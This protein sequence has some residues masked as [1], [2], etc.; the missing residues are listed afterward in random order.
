MRLFEKPLESLTLVEARDR[1]HHL[2]RNMRVGDIEAL[3][4]NPQDLAGDT[5]FIRVRKSVLRRL[6][7]LVAKRNVT[8]GRSPGPMYIKC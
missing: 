8:S 7:E 5:E 3:E 2:I 4:K 6:N 1:Y